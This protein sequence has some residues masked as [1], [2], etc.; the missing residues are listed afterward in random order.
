MKKLLGII[1]LG[2][3][4]SANLLADDYTISENSCA[5]KWGISCF[6]LIR[7]KTTTIMLRYL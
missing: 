7:Q 3:F 6:W 1:V 2:F 4:L 5:T